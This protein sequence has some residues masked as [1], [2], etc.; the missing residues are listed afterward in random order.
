MKDGLAIIYYS[1]REHGFPEG[2]DKTWSIGCDLDQDN[3]ETIREH[4]KRWI[5]D[6]TFVRV[7]FKPVQRKIEEGV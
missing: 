1:Q 4:L 3:E 5:P 2:R 7:E 6:A